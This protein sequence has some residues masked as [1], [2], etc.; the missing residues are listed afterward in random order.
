MSCT[1]RWFA[2]V[3]GTA[4][5]LGA[6]DFTYVQKTEITGG[7]MKRFI[8]MAAR[9]SKQAAAPQNT[10]HRFSGDQMSVQSGTSNTVYDLAKETITHI[11]MD[12]MQYSVITFAE[13]AQAMKNM[14]GKMAGAK[15]DNS[16]AAEVKWKAT[17]DITGKTK[18]VAGVDTK[19]AVMKVVMEGSN[20][21][22]PGAVAG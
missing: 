22:Q 3:L 17:V 5:I 14:G 2:A 10:T 16:N 13:M 21:N 12:K 8:D 19:E 6:A 9:F 15:K 20:P 4:A 18:P 7:S 1:M 11:E